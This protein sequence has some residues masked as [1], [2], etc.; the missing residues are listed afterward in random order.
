MQGL[1]ATQNHVPLD[2]YFSQSQKQILAL[3][4]NGDARGVTRKLTEN[5]GPCEKAKKVLLDSPGA[6]EVRYVNAALAGTRRFIVSPNIL[7]LTL[8]RVWIGV[9]DIFQ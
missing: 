4:G 5:I 1:L 3:V 8:E 9:G 2:C 7:G 6:T